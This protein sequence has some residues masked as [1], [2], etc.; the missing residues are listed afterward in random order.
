METARLRL[1]VLTPERVPDLFATLGS[2]PDIYRWLNFARPETLEEFT[3]VMNN[4][5]AE[6]AAGLRIAHAV[7][8]KST[9]KAIGTT[10]LMDLKTSPHMLE[11]GSTFYAKEYWR[12]FVNTECK[13]MMLTEAF[14]SRR[15]ERVYFKTDSLNE[16]SRNAI[17]RIG[18][19]FE[20]ILRHHMKRP[21]GTWRD[22]AY[23][24]ILKD[25]WPTVKANLQNKLQ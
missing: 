14:E 18:A 22:S 3:Q 1:E 16:R 2:E 25:E 23:F 20:G 9:N 7:I 8:E 4:L 5:I 13:L 15:V 19:R 24:S 21:D 10:S 17:L 6:T 11:I 12:S